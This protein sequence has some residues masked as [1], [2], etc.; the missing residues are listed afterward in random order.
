MSKKLIFTQ[1]SQQ[2]LMKSKNQ[3]TKRLIG[4]GSRQT[5]KGEY[6]NIFVQVLIVWRGGG[7]QGRCERRSEVFGVWGM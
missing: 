4:D 2:N 7:G 5:N 1:R 3:K 6:V